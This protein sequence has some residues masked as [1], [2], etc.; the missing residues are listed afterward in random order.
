MHF[1]V[2]D[3]LVQMSEYTCRIMSLSAAAGMVLL[4]GHKFA[5]NYMKSFWSYKALLSKVNHV[6]QIYFSNALIFNYDIAKNY[7]RSTTRISY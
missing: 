5:Y 4:H 1:F 6:V 3:L 2:E 7:E